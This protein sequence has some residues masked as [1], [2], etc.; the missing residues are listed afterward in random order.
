M[1]ATVHNAHLSQIVSYF[2]ASSTGDRCSVTRLVGVRI[3]TVTLAQQSHSESTYHPGWRD[4]SNSPL[5]ALKQ[6]YQAA[7]FSEEVSS[8]AAAPRRPSTNCMYDDRWLRFAYW[9]AGQEMD[10]LGPTAAQIATF[11]YFLVDTHGLSLMI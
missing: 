4:I 9:A 10:P 11:L 3:F 2:G 8:F 7:G 5:E 6:H 1:F